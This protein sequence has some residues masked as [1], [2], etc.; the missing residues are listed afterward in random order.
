M[1]VIEVTHTK[2]EF[3]MDNR[4]EYIA[5]LVVKVLNGDQSAFAEL[6][7]MTCD[8]V[9]AYTGRYLRDEFLAE[10]AVQEIYILAY[11]N[12]QKLNDPSLFVA[13]L[14][15]ISFRVCYDLDKKRKGE[16]TDVNSELLSEVVG[17]D[18]FSNPEE[19]IAN[20]DEYSRLN[21][22]LEKLS[23]ADKQFLTL[24]YYK[25]KKID[26]IAEMTGL[27][28]STVKR[29]INTAVENLRLELGVA[30]R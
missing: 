25:N 21:E 20:N 28:K 5:G 30:L 22:A 2:G 16:D 26:D 24:R 19:T 23:P 8:K 13:W 7:S 6:Y 3:N 17:T 12:I 10:D 11:K 14:N 4:H 9:F 27:S 1:S 15:Q 18:S 29:H